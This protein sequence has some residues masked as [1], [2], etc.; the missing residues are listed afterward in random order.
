MNKKNIIVV[1]IL[2]CLVL[3]GLVG[4]QIYWIKNALA[5]KRTNFERNI[6]E[7]ATIVVNKLEKLEVADQINK[8]LNTNQ[9]GQDLF[10][11]IDSINY[12]YLKELEKRS[13]ENKPE[14]L[15]GISS[16]KIQIQ[17]SERKN[18]KTVKHYDTTIV[19]RSGHGTY[20]P[21]Q[22][23]YSE[24]KT[25]GKIPDQP[26]D[27]VKYNSKS[28]M[29]TL[30]QK[31]NTLVKE[32]FNELFNF[33]HVQPIEERVDPKILDSL[34]TAELRNKGIETPFEFGIFSSVRNRMV[35]Q[36]TGDYTNELLKKSLGFI[37]F[38]NDM[39]ISPDYLMIYFPN[40]KR[41]LFTKIA[42][43]L[44]I[45]IILIITIIILFSYAISTI[46]KQKK[47]SE[48]KNDFIN[49]MTHEFKTP[50]STISLACQALNDP[51]I[52]K[53]DGLP[54]N[55]IHI[56]NEE[57]NRLGG[58]AEKILQTAI[59]E[60]GK[61]NLKRE[62]I[63]VHEIIR[64]VIKNMGLQ[65]ESRGGSIATDFQAN[66]S[67][68]KA[69]KVH[70]TNLINNL[71]DNANKYTHET[72]E[73]VVATENFPDGILISIKDNGIG[74]SK[75][76]QKKIFEHLYRVPTGNIHDVK[77]FGLGLTYV[78]AI[79]EKHGGSISVESELKKGSKFKVFLPFDNNSEY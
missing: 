27:S 42:G 50:I 65:I 43:M 44:S 39:P 73:I 46:I 54:D 4:V 40:E 53:I 22:P 68:I 52:K 48:M 49:N 26:S 77:G 21:E 78:K 2:V 24:K 36:K 32:V 30:M 66:L 5:V 15:F 58:M 41:Y 20:T 3:V 79:I 59:I 35:Y 47:L 13:G 75:A 69:D 19:S 29:K 38:P 63:D 71:L 61:L 56:I 64:D 6:V 55:Y 25:I 18:G 72:P 37:L 8:Q 60:K 51:D 12:L 74:I 14:N 1:T 28:R 70:I 17:Y 23:L 16:E 31:K 34:L 57:N 45:S 67:Q 76:N 10:T 9:K 62:L 33:K 11:T 7:T